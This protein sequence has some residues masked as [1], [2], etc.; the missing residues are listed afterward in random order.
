MKSSLP[1]IIGMS[2]L[3]V[4]T[5][6]TPLPISSTTGQSY[7]ID[8]S[9]FK[10]NYNEGH[11]KEA[12]EGVV[13][14]TCFTADSTGVTFNIQCK[15]NTL[16]VVDSEVFCSTMDDKTVRIRLVSEWT[17]EEADEILQNL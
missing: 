16:N 4:L 10:D 7:D 11:G 8:V 12:T 6:C 3:V 1:Y 9:C 2:L 13:M 14:A 17:N 5:G 15:A